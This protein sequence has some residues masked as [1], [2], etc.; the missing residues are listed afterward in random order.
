MYACLHG[1]L[2]VV[3]VV[4]DDGI[5]VVV[6]VVVVVPA[7]RWSLHKLPSQQA[8]ATA[9]LRP[10]ALTAIDVNLLHNYIK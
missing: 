1:S 3:V 8:P 6:V 9:R 2:V 4:V 7:L 10:N 5:V